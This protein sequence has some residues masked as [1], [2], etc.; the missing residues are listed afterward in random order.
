MKTKLILPD[1]I[2]LN[3]CP[4]FT[5]GRTKV[6]GNYPCFIV[7]E[8]GIN[9]D[10]KFDQ[11]IKLIETASEAKCS[12]VKF[13]MFRADKMYAKNP[14]QF[15]VS[16]G[17]RKD[18]WKIIKENELS[19]DWI[20]RLKKFASEKGLEFFSSVC[21]EKSADIMNS[22]NIP[23]YKI[24]SSELTHLPLLQYVAKKGKPI[25]L[26]SGAATLAEL[27]EAYETC[28][29]AGN[30]QIAILHCIAEYPAP[31]NSL[32]LKI[33]STLRMTFP[34]V[35]VGF[36]DHSTD[37]V[38]AP[39][40]AVSFGAKIIEKHI[41]LNKNLPGADHAFALNPEELKS[42]V[43]EIR[44]TEKILIAKKKFRIEERIIGSGERK[45]FELERERRLF[46]F[47]S[48]FALKNISS[49]ESFNRRNIAVLRP[50]N[51]FPGLH[52]KIFD[53]ITNG[54]VAARDIPANKALEWPDI[55]N[56]KSR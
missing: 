24:A 45:T 31:L 6:G 44:R 51:N 46:T 8:I 39:N 15:R 55:L 34:N 43:Q 37:P 48:I 25:I 42:M 50:G 33:I 13:Q 3:K 21:D 40:A 5:I 36:S 32:N 2:E 26:S 30:R 1:L 17:G 16:N 47:R 28:L 12:A 27:I 35:I 19:K 22:F 38:V 9:F 49:G 18:I 7:A 11:A 52:P 41:T 29:D 53:V 14:G 4:S 20:L 10:G 23:A 54:F 56:Q